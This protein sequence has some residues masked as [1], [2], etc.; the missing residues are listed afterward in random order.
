MTF[1]HFG[2]HPKMTAGF[3]TAETANRRCCNIEDVRLR[4]GKS[5]PSYSRFSL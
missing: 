2:D 4:L 1:M 5:F 3:I